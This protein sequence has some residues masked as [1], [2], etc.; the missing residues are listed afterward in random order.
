MPERVYDLEDR[1]VDFAISIIDI[2][3]GLPNGRA[4][5]HIA[6]QLIR[7][8]TSPAPNYSE[9]MSAESKQDFI[10]KI[11]IALKELRESRVWMK[12][13]IRRRYLQKDNEAVSAI[14]ECEELIRILSASVK[15]ASKGK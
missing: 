1:L 3:E 5:N 8:G 4:T 9:S 10:H 11:K 12:I 2:V 6:S 15:T 14:N 13:I 7:S